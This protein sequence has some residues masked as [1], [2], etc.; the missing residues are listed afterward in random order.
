MEQVFDCTLGTRRTEVLHSESIDETIAYID[1]TQ[2]R[3]LWICDEHTRMLLPFAFDALVLPAGEQTKTWRIVRM[4]IRE[5]MRRK[6]GRDDRFVAFGGG[7]ICDVTAFAASLYMRGCRLILVPTSLLAMVDAS[8]G[9]KSA[10]NLDNTK[11]I[12]GSFYPAECVVL[13]FET[14]ASLSE[15]EYHNGLGEVIK[16]ALLAKEDALACFL[17][18][19]RHSLL[20][21]K[22]DEIAC[23]I[24]QS[25]AV[26]KYYLERDPEETLGIREALNLG[27]TFAHAL[28][29]EGKLIAWSHGEAV[30]WG[31]SRALE[32]GVRTHITPNDLQ[33]RYETLLDAYRFDTRYRVEKPRAFF[34]ALRHDKKKRAD[35]IRFILM[36]DQGKPVFAFLEDSLVTSLI[37]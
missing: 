33:Q 29:S 9:G 24:V 15:R 6:F 12:I 26:K 16:H 31:L 20:Q 28:E 32:A 23:M 4:I 17:E 14:I 22:T 35:Q 3:S 18:N 11:N 30:A 19:H 5:A 37:R 10:I 1:E 2:G 34:A 25:L 21:R 13:C 8:V 36:E 7:V 27:H